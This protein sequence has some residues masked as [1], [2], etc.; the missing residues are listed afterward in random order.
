MGRRS[1]FTLVETLIAVVIVSILTL[2]AYPRV[3]NAIVKSDVHSA[4][5]RVVNMLA[6]ARSAA[7]QSNRSTWLKF[8][9]NLA[10]VEAFPRRTVGGTGN[11]DTLGTV[12]DLSA[13]YKTAV[14]LTSGDTQIAY[15][16]RGL[17][18]G[19]TTGGVT[20]SLTRSGYSQT[21]KLDALGR[22]TK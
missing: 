13:M 14:S 3:S 11:R 10:W 1:G 17:A 8:N 18:S 4:R 2:M 15:D 20:I 5:T 9:G 16:P 12:L 22:V 6:A 7:A 19:F 21:V